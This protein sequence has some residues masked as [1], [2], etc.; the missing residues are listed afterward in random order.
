M[1]PIVFD[2]LIWKPGYKLALDIPEDIYRLYNPGGDI[3]MSICLSVKTEKKTNDNIST[4]FNVH[5]WIPIGPNKYEKNIAKIY[6]S[7]KQGIELAMS[8]NFITS[9]PKDDYFFF[10]FIEGPD[11]ISEIADIDGE[12]CIFDIDR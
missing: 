12:I 9:V 6:I 4:S 11:N 3:S 10:F 1:K 2:K 7:A 5:I 8:T